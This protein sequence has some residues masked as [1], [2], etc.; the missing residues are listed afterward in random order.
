MAQW[1]VVKHRHV[2][3]DVTVAAEEALSVHKVGTQDARD[4]LQDTKLLRLPIKVVVPLPLS[5][6][7]CA[8]FDN[9]V[10]LGELPVSLRGGLHQRHDV[11]LVCVSVIEVPCQRQVVIQIKLRAFW[12]IV[13]HR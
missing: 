6:D 2:E 1:L 11:N 3:V 9:W 4:W 12:V 8:R 10:I 13:C 5:G 7:S